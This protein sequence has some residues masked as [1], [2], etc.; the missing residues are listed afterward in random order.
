MKRISTYGLVLGLLM[1]M[2]WPA[3]A[4]A[5][6]VWICSVTGGVECDAD[7][8]VGDPEMSGLM[9]PTFIRVDTNKK[10]ITLLAPQ[11]RRGEVT[12]IDT[13]REEEDTWVLTGIEEGRAWSIVISKDGYL[14]VSVTY[15]GA[16]WSAFGHTMLEE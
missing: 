7:G 2:V 12:V 11:S 13:V 9:A 6:P 16:T 15:D 1:F 14:T 5:R 4:G 3:V 10:Q 8:T